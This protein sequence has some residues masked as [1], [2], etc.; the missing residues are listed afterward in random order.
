MKEQ[1]DKYLPLSWPLTIFLPLF[2]F[3]LVYL[4]ISC[5]FV[6]CF[7]LNS[8]KMI[9]IITNTGALCYLSVLSSAGRFAKYFADTC[10]FVSHAAPPGRY[11]KTEA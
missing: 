2:F 9:S 6:I 1:A 7:K 10:I 3:A 11:S 8:G 4:C 5:M